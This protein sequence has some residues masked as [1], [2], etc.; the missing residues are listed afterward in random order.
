MADVIPSTT[1][2]D[3]P[4]WFQSTGT[5]IETFSN[6]EGYLHVLQNY[7]PDQ[8]ELTQEDADLIIK[9]LLDCGLY[10]L[11]ARIVCERVVNKTPFRE[12]AKTLKIT[13]TKT[14]KTIYMKGLEKFFKVLNH[15]TEGRQQ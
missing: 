15:P 8:A 2:G 5:E 4:R 14:A 1:E 12:I 11:Q 6:E 7:F 13:N 3:H 9:R 10:E